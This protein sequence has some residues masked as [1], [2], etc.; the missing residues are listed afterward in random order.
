M[1]S[2]ETSEILTLD[3]ILFDLTPDLIKIDTDGY[4]INVLRG[5]RRCLRDAGPHLWIEYSPYH[6]R[7]YG[8]EEPTNLF[9]LLREAGYRA[10][11]IYDNTGYPIC[12]VELHASEL[13]MIAGYVDIK[14]ELYADLLVSKDRDLLVRFF[15]ADRRRFASADWPFS[16]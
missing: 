11:I 9:P 3:D 10:T 16:A 7:T 8:F 5:A 2:S 15:E 1:T 4:D 14:P 13:A 12:L 6:I